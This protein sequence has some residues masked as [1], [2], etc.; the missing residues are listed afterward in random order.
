MLNNVFS[1]THPKSWRG[2]LFGAMICSLVAS[3]FSLVPQK[4]AQ[5]V[6]TI[7]TSQYIDLDS[8]GTIDRIRWAI[9]ETITLCDYEPGDWSIDTAGTINVTSIDALS[10]AGSNL[11]IYVT[12]DANVSG[13]VIN[14]VISY[15]NQGTAGSVSLTSGA[16]SSKAGVT[17]TDGALP[18]L[19]SVK[20]GASGSAVDTTTLTFSE[21]VTVV[22]NDGDWEA[23]PNSLTGFDVTG[24]SSGNGTSEV[25]LTATV[26]GNITGRQDSTASEPTLSFF[27]FTG[28]ITDD[29]GNPDT[30]GIPAT[31]VQ[32][33]AAPSLVS[34]EYQDPDSDGDVSRVLATFT[35]PVT[36]SALQI[37]TVANDLTGFTNA[38]TGVNTSYT[39]QNIIL[40]N[41]GTTSN[42]KTGVFSGTEPTITFSGTAIADQS[43]QANNYAGSTES[44]TD[45]AAPVIIQVKYEDVSGDGTVDSLDFV[46]SEVIEVA[47]SL[48]AND[49]VFGDVGDFTGSVFGSSLTDRATAQATIVTVPLGTP[50]T[51]VDTHEDS[52]NV[53]I[54]TQNGFSLIDGAGNINDT[55]GVQ[56]QVAYVD[57]ADPV[58]KTSSPATGSTNFT[59]LSNIRLT[60]SEAMNTVSTEGD[61]A[62]SD[63]GAVTFVGTWSGSNSILTINP[64]TTLAANTLHT[65]DLGVL[66][67]A[68]TDDGDTLTPPDVTFTT[69][70]RTTTGSGGGGGSSTV[71][72][73]ET[74]C[75]V[76]SPNGG[77]I[78]GKDTVKNI[79][80]TSTGTGIDNLVIYHQSAT[81][82]PW[83][84]IVAGTPNDGSYDWQVPS[85]LS[86]ASK[87]RIEC[88]DSGAAT[89]AADESDATFTIATNL[90][91]IDDPIVDS[92]L[93]TR[94]AANFLLPAAF[95]VDSLVKLADDGDAS[96]TVD[97]AV[98]YIG[99]DAKR[100]PFP[101]LAIYSSWY[102]DFSEVQII[103]LAT[104]ADISL[105]S[106]VLVRPGTHWVKIQSDPKT[107]Y[108]APGYTLRWVEDE[109][110]A[111]MLG[112]ENWNQNIIDIEPTFFARFT[113]GEKIMA[114]DLVN[115]WP[116]GSL[117]KAPGQTD[118]WYT[119]AN[120]RRMVTGGAL[121][122]NHFQT[123]FVKTLTGGWQN[124]TQGLNIVGFEDSLFS[125]MLP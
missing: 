43:G 97:S 31:T 19:L 110:T 105:G 79:S 47:S 116:A 24:I 56:S 51:V 1:S 121:T 78:I 113:V 84:M 115:S 20:Y 28:S 99:L 11:Y 72:V 27:P 122:V 92:V 29:A 94:E 111:I 75:T 5:A 65:L 108:V 16:L 10:C 104:L 12:T 83:N 69:G 61:M 17:V 14:P 30:D 82:G 87:I 38:N 40:L 89:L 59:R 101:S 90:V 48:A 98:Y 34:V 117:V 93:Y 95:P 73:V 32:D 76:V 45:G 119:D 4:F 18:A 91:N 112:G 23:T 3:S 37:S 2:F 36:A 62:L 42:S 109:A 103:D 77:E 46:F 71:P 106:A 114:S 21:N 33:Y 96:T 81:N 58:L 66:Y 100:H 68:D 22:Y 6:D 86:N 50:A 64:D 15:T 124:A 74:S 88:R 63:G 54:T 8:D 60:F 49:F 25:V 118:V 70:T 123:R 67:S 41:F 52:G 55:L 102:T 44:L 13:G 9:D 26:T 80:W 7:S 39:N 53:S 107:Y 120:G 125:E 35:E 85:E 57:I